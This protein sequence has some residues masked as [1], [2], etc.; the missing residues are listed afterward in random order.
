LILTKLLRIQRQPTGAGT[1]EAGTSAG[2]GDM[3]DKGVNA[4]EQ[5]SGLA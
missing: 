4:L 3:L 5:K 1:T 2:H